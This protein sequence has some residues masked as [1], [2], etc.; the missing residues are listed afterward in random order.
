MLHAL[1]LSSI[2]N[3]LPFASNLKRSAPPTSNR[4]A[5]LPH[6]LFL[7][8]LSTFIPFV[9]KDLLRL[10]ELILGNLVAVTMWSIIVIISS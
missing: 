2:R 10:K 1:C 7:P 4:E 9:R 3:Y 5:P 6:A 8:T